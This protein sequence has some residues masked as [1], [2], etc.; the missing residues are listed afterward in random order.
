[1]G[2]VRQEVGDVRQEVAEL[3]R[4]H[5]AEDDVSF[6][7]PTGKQYEAFVDTKVDD[8]L[9]D[10]YG[11]RAGNLIRARLVRRYCRGSSS[12][13][14]S[15]CSA[16]ELLAL[17]HRIFWTLLPWLELLARTCARKLW[18]RSFQGL[19]AHTR[20]CGPCSWHAALSFFSASRQF[21]LERLCSL[22]RH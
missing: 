22:S 13:S 3:R 10:F 20:T 4:A 8:W 15:A 6:V 14:P 21:L 9:R 19:T 18:R 7:S 12:D 1:M 11:M 5:D 2:D 16:L 17:P